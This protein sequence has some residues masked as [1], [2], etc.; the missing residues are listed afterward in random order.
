MSHLAT[1]WDAD[2]GGRGR[3]E[4]AANWS[5]AGGNGGRGGGGSVWVDV[6][7]HQCNRDSSIYIWMRASNTTE[8]GIL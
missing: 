2:R 5:R 3:G 4:N 7:E 1:I 6:R 8:V